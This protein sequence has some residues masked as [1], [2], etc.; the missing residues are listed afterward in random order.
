MASCGGPGDPQSGQ[1][2]ENHPGRESLRFM[3]PGPRRTLDGSSDSAA[4]GIV[5]QAVTAD[6]DGRD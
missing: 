2:F 3:F 4:N 1:E 5:R 6:S